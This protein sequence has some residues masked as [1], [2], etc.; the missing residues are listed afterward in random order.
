MN[1]TPMPASI[2]RSSRRKVAQ[3][4]PPANEGREQ[5]RRQSLLTSAATKRAGVSQIPLLTFF[6]TVFLILSVFSTRAATNDVSSLLQKGLFEEEANRNL[7]AAI[8]AYQAV[9]NETDKHHQFA[10][11]AVFRLAECYR[12][13]GKT[14]EANALYERILRE[15]PD[16]AD[17][18]KLSEQQV[19][20]SLAPPSPGGSDGV[21]S[22][23]QKQIL[24]AQT[25]AE[26]SR[27][28]SQYLVNLKPEQRRV[29]VQQSYPNPVL[30][31]L[32]QKLTE[33]EQELAK[34]LKDMGSNH[35]D[36][37]RAVVLRD[38]IERQIDDQIDGVIRGLE[39]K[40]TSAEETAKELETRLQQARLASSPPPAPT[41]PAS[42]P[43]DPEAEEIKHLQAMIKDS[44]DLINAYYQGSPD[45]PL[46]RAVERGQL[47]VVTFLL[48]HKANI[49]V[50][51]K[52]IREQRAAG[53]TPLLV[54][55]KQG[56]KEMVELLLNR[57][58]DI[59][60]GAS[61]I[62]PGDPHGAGNTALHCAAELGYKN[63]AEVLLAHGANVN[64][65]DVD[66]FTPLHFAA[67]KGFRAVGELLLAHG[68]DPNLKDDPGETPLHLA[69]EANSQ[70]MVELLLANKADVNCKTAKGSAPL[71]FAASEGHV[72]IAKLLLAS[73]PEVNSTNSDG[74]TPLHVA[75]SNNQV[76]VAKL[77]LAHGA[78]VNATDRGG[79]TP[80]M[81]AAEQ[82]G[83]EMTKLL[84][85]RD[86]NP[87]AQRWWGGNTALSLAKA[88]A[89]REPQTADE[90]ATLLRK[91]GADE[92]LQRR[93]IIGVSRGEFEQDFFFKGTNSY[94]R[95]TLFELLN[96]FYGPAPGI[97][98][99]GSLT[100]PDFS[101]ITIH[102]LARDG[103][104]DV[105]VNL[106]PALESG[107]CSG[108]QW[109][110]WGDIV[111]IPEQGHDPSDRWGL[112]SKILQTL[113]ECLKRTVQIV[114]RDETENIALIPGNRPLIYA[115][116]ERP[117]QAET[118]PPP[119]LTLMSFDLSSVVRDAKVITES[120]DLSRIKVRRT[121]P[122]TKKVTEMV[123]SLDTF[124][125][126][127]RDGDV[128]EIPEKP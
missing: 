25:E 56:N 35:P 87:N 97:S 128:I 37:K 98:T 120:S 75:A 50:R 101:R 109:L 99:P 16:Q 55:A 11:T 90:I 79:S 3:T 29:A 124:N 34:L 65:R 2:F 10:A 19:G 36:V 96:R 67:Q 42:E 13:Q 33:T 62:N 84:L 104:T 95:Y 23:L 26:S 72:E 94:N 22:E 20:H 30:N 28:Q 103:R 117:V 105:K 92:S 40:M 68:A 100:F 78:D 111:E 118:S 59:N 80:L 93:S 1:T 60:A 18:V 108:D 6:I 126:R 71:H 91:A 9:I 52:R 85:A 48:D 49:E 17:L 114:T 123:G 66:Q 45:N 82:G 77:L 63:I 110:E 47:K 27:K 106:Q 88:R 21:S 14:Q 73:K 41:A 122:V 61:R 51:D 4:K 46:L 38:E 119:R 74:S 15:F 112:D 116:P 86:A 81:N 76:E 58:A 69:V 89:S 121:D 107:D 53:N 43:A 8:L 44:P 102:R 31:S 127:L 57:G 115:R 24:A 125:L 54:A 83:V 7:D 70:P 5:K 32:M 64:A 113:W 12:K 39:A